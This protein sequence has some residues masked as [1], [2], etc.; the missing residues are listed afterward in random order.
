MSKFKE[1]S[2]Q[3]K[4][5]GKT[6]VR[7]KETPTSSFRKQKCCD[8]KC[9]G[10]LKA[11]TGRKIMKAKFGEDVYDDKQCLVCN[12]T[13]SKGVKE[14]VEVYSK[15]V[16]CSKSCSAIH[17]HSKSGKT[18][19]KFKTLKQA[20]SRWKPQEKLMQKALAMPVIRG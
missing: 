4:N 17:V 9:N 1:M 3:C 7:K 20:H 12:V 18:V 11:K 10:E 15:R 16:T 14:G 8:L 13:F 19:K 2:K 5:C 6:F